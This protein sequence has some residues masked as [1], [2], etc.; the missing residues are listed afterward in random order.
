MARIP[1]KYYL[2]L[3]PE[4]TIQEAATSLKEEMKALFNLKYALKSPAHI[5]VKMP[6]E[7]NE[8]K[9]H[10]L[11]QKLGEFFE[12][13]QAFDLKFEGFDHF[14]R[15]VIFVDV[16]PS[17]VLEALQKA[18]NDFCK[19]ELKLNNELSDKAFH[20]HMTIS[21][22]DLKPKNFELYWKHFQTKSF[23]AD[24]FVKDVAL[25]KR[26]EGRWQVIYRFTLKS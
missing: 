6:F 9:E 7:W 10:V 24:Y 21:F 19:R 13:F 15:R 11:I 23:E 8:N 18:L 4:G 26:L 16:Q 2:A 25:L 1:A 22:K 12:P 3:V 20:P 5:T 17:A 14:G